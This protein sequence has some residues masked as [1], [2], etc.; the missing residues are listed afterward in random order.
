QAGMA[1]SIAALRAAVE[2]AGGAQNVYGFF[3][4]PVQERTGRVLPRDFTAALAALR[5]ELDLPMIAVENTT[6]G[7]R[8]GLGAFAAGASGLRPDVIA[9]WGGAQTGYLHVASRWFV[10]TPLALV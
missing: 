5:D 6:C 4:E 8:S 7:Y 9:W 2:A 1:A 10:A 3:Y